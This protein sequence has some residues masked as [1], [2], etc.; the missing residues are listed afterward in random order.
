MIL[1]DITHAN[2]Y[3]LVIRYLIISLATGAVCAGA[4]CAALALPVVL[5]SGGEDF[6][7]LLD[8]SLLG[9]DHHSIAVSLLPAIHNKRIY[10]YIYIC[11]L[12]V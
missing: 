8:V 9:L 1:L 11:Y 5:S 7:N 10:I 3:M 2:H 4:G 12:H 6:D